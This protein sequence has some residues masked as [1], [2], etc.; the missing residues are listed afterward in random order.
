MS[1]IRALIPVTAASAVLALA[2]GASAGVRVWS[3]PKGDAMARRTDPGAD[4]EIGENAV[5]PDLL[6]TTLSGW[7]PASMQNPFDGTVNSAIF[8]DVLRIELRFDGLVNPPGPL[9]P[10]GPGGL[11]YDPFKYG[12]SPLYGFL[13]LDVDDNPD[14]GGEFHGVASSRYLA[15]VARFGRTPIEGPAG[16]AIIRQGQKDSDFTTPPQFERSGAEFAVALCGCWDIQ[17]ISQSGNGD[18][19]FDPGERWVVNGRFFERAQAFE[20]LSFM[21][22]DPNNGG[23]SMPGLYDPPINVRFTHDAEADETVVELIFPLTMQGAAQLYGGSVQQ[24]NFTFGGSNHFS[25]IEALIDL[26]AGAL[27]ASSNCAVLAGA[28]NGG[29][30]PID[31]IDPANWR[32]TALFGTAYEDEQPVARFVW[33]DTGFCEHAGDFNSDGRSD[34]TDVALLD[35]EIQTLDG[36]E[37]DA[38]GVVNGVVSVPSFGSTFSMFDLNYNGG[39]DEM[40]AMLLT[41]C[42]ADYAKPYGVLDFSDVLEFLEAFDAMDP[43]ADLAPPMGGFDYSDVF[44]FLIAFGAGC[45]Q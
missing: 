28:W 18:G 7:N 29:Q 2:P 43:R 30:S 8:P 40:D 45:P 10:D 19:K 21:F 34:A 44:A 26:V 3:D 39:V 5:L 16:R 11:A 6:S 1:L 42:I 9:D 27:G 32:A 20:C 14:T 4:A 31:F 13:E 25:F 17:I 24:P 38:D 35:Q 22:G 36:T 37:L 12:P 23:P 15:N 41:P 33:T